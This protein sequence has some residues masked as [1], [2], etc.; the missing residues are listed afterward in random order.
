MSDNI[1]KGIII[2][3][4]ERVVV[5]ASLL[6]V[7]TLLIRILPEADFGIYKLIGS[8]VAFAGYVF[9][10]GLGH[11]VSRFV[12]DFLALKQYKNTNNLILF[13]SIACLISV[14]LI[15]IASYLFGDRIGNLLNAPVIFGNL[16]LP[17]VFYISLRLIN[18][19]IGNALL[20][21]YSQRR[22]IGY[23]RITSKILMLALIVL[24]YV[25]GKGLRTVVGILV[26]ISFCE[27][28]IYLPLCISKVV[29]NVKNTQSQ[30]SAGGG[31]DQSF[32]FRRIIRFALY[33]YLWSGGQVF[34]EYS[35]DNFV[36]SYFKKISAVAFYGIAT[37]IPGLLRDVSPT[38]MLYGVLLPVM[39]RKYKAHEQQHEI[40]L[41]Y[42]FLQKINLIFVLPITVFFFTFAA[43]LIIFAYG[44]AYSVSVLPAMI[45]IGFSFLQALSD[46][47]YVLSQVIEKPSAIFYSTIWGIY[48]LGMNFVLV[49]FFGIEGAAIATGTASLFIFLYFTLVYKYAYKVEFTFPWNALKKILINMIGFV[50]S[51]IIIKYLNLL[52]IFGLGLLIIGISSYLGMCSVNK[53]FDNRE[54]NILLRRVKLLRFIV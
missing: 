26:V 46:P 25:T 44:E 45:L 19:V 21:G 41:W 23:V 4:A 6:L 14:L 16:F 48:N 42:V 9:S 17:V 7:S 51:I 8:I 37:V 13:S 12:P 49:P 22:V 15:I 1:T 52:N 5:A 54:R 27:F 40:A 32:P 43:E 39:V 28:I 36:I 53:I 29:Q 3:Y 47:F 31:K 34:R 24:V 38:R 50:I 33:N 2:V 18:V 10:F 20:I 11:T 35:V 30:N